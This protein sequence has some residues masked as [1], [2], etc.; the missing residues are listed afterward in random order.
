MRSKNT[1]SETQALKN[2][3]TVLASIKDRCPWSSDFYEQLAQSLPGVRAFEQLIKEGCDADDLLSGLDRCCRGFAVVAIESQGFGREI[4][5]ISLDLI[6]KSERLERMGRS[7][8]ANGVTKLLD[9]PDLARIAQELKALGELLSQEATLLSRGISSREAPG[10]A[11]A[12]LAARVE[13]F[14]GKAHYSDIACLLEIQFQFRG[15]DKDISSRA[16][17]KQVK[18]FRQKH[19]LAYR[20]M[21]NMA[22]RECGKFDD[23]PMFA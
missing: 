3:R 1:D 13:G 5:G 9:R 17:Q 16:I 19:S 23:S 21:R 20:H 6:S 7:R 14:T 10:L 12:W 11:T 2:V 4:A 18:R 8:A 22:R 15:K